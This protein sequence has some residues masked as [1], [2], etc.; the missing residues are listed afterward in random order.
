M[1]FQAAG[2]EHNASLYINAMHYALISHLFDLTEGGIDD[3][4]ADRLANLVMDKRNYGP[5]TMD[6]QVRMMAYRA[7]LDENYW[8]IAPPPKFDNIYTEDGQQ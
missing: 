4:E 3:D 1:P 8:G 5:Q 6:S 7:L 2:C